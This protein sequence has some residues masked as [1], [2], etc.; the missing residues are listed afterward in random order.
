MNE[1]PAWLKK[2]FP[3]EQKTL[4]VNGR[5]MAYLDEGDV[6]AR[7]VL[8]LHGNPTWGFLYR[9]FVGPLVS[10]DYRVIV[11]DWI[12][13]GYSDHPRID[14]VFTL[15]HHIADLVSLI[16]QL[17]LRSF[18]IVGYTGYPQGVGAALQRVE[19]LDAL[20]LMNTWLF[21]DS[22]GKFHQSPL[23]GPPGGSTDRTVADEALQGSFAWRSF[24]NHATHDDRRRKARLSSRVRRTWTRSAGTDLAATIP[25]R[26]GD[27]GWSDMQMI[28]RRFPNWLRC[29]RCCCGPGRQRLH[30]PVRESAC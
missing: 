25:L 9:D 12:G 27:R 18:V 21:T 28:Q 6:D 26:E 1:K 5:S 22:I 24:R 15:A 23:P 7:P 19:R 13:C 14:A 17:R 30:D 29:R 20:V 10:A 8:L 3:W 11:P 16:D 2:M 4:Q